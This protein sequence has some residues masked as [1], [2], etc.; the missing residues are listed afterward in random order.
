M[1]FI[2]AMFQ[3][4]KHGKFFKR[5]SKSFL[6]LSFLIGASFYLALMALNIQEQDQFK[7]RSNF[8]SKIPDSASITGIY[9][10]SSGTWIIAADTVIIGENLVLNGSIQISSGH[11]LS[12]YN[13]NI[14]FSN[15]SYEIWGNTATLNIYNSSI[16]NYDQIRM[17]VQSS[18]NFTQSTFNAISKGLDASD[19][20][21]IVKG[22]S[23]R[24]IK[25]GISLWNIDG[26][27]I[28]DTEILDT[29]NETILISYSQNIII[30]NT[31]L[32]GDG[33]TYECVGINVGATQNLRVINSVIENFHKSVFY[34]DVDDSY[35]GYSNFSQTP[36]SKYIDGELQFTDGSDNI[37]IEHNYINNL[38]YDGIEIY[39]S[40]H[41]YIYNN[42][43]KN[44][45]AGTHI[46][47]PFIGYLTIINNTFL[48]S[49]PI[50]SDGTNLLITGNNIVNGEIVLNN[51]SDSE[52]SYNRI[53]Q[54]RIRVDNS[55][56]ITE[57]GNIYS[58]DN[59]PG[60]LDIDESG[61]NKISGGMPWLILGISSISVILIIK[62]SKSRI[63]T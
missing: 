46:E 17:A 29:L 14:T 12:I 33:P 7:I 13:S 20:S 39:Q 11:T 28:E 2:I 49:S 60:D 3:H 25:Q 23:F 22:C 44:V 21:L 27:T 36:N 59:L 54:G 47:H 43:I 51:C 32:R 38:T 30:N 16:E 62:K 34:Q 53:C 61:L 40:N 5:R 37:T 57:I 48:N 18:I 55:H 63:A 42:T 8:S 19:S 45:G 4:L 6:F 15:N 24:S 52:I 10:P 26:A 9:P 31:H 56:N 35:I 41:Y 58:C 50:I 1:G